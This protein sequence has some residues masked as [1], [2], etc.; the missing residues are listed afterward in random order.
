MRKLSPFK[1]ITHALNSVVTYRHVAIRIGMFWIPVLIVLGLVEMWAGPPSPQSLESGSVNLVQIVSAGV[2][3]VGFCSM[4]VSW[5]RFILRDE[6]G[7]PMRLDAPVWRYVGNS[8][9][10]MLMVLVPVVILAVVLSQVAPVASVLL[11]PVI[12]VSGALI[13]RLSIKLPAVAL[14]RRDFG[15][16]DAWNASAGN[17]W[18]LLGLFLLNAAIVFGMILLLMIV[19]GGLT[20]ISPMLAQIVALALGAAGQL[21]YTLFNASIFTSLYGFFVERRDF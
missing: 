2:S 19:I 1:A 8:I 15:F 21:F 3:L 11:I 13:S 9:L 5:H 4:A 14:D 17:F 6:L 10:I 12:L 20:Q 18:Q 7:S 16:R